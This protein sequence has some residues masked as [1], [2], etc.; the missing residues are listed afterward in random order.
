ML[1]S[2]PS[3]IIISEVPPGIL[4]MESRRCLRVNDSIPFLV[5]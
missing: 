4:S 2:R 5:S 3:F 1:K